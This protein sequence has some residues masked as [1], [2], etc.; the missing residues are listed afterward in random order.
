MCGVGDAVG[1]DEYTRAG[2]RV[3]GFPGP[4][5]LLLLIDAALRPLA[6]FDKRVEVGDRACLIVPIAIFRSCAELRLDSVL[7]YAPLIDVTH[8]QGREHVMNRHNT[9]TNAE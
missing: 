5:Q 9:H 8:H 4:P 2:T 3:G 6:N 7:G 1:L